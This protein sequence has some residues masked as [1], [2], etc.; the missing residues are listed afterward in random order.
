[1]TRIGQTVRPRNSRTG[2]QW[3]V[4]GSIVWQGRTDWHLDPIGDDVMPAQEHG[5]MNGGV[6]SIY[7][8]DEQLDDGWVVVSHEPPA[9]ILVGQGHIG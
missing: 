2:R 6:R 5:R 8:T 9:T 4:V 7:R 3:R 1:M